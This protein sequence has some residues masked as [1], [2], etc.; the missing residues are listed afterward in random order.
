MMTTNTIAKNRGRRSIVIGELLITVALVSTACGG[1]STSSGN[2]AATATAV[3]APTATTP[4]PVVYVQGT[5]QLAGTT[6]VP[7]VTSIEL[8]GEGDFQN[9]VT[10][11]TG[12]D[13]KYAFSDIERDGP[14][15]VW[16]L[17]NAAAKMIPHCTDVI[18]PAEWIG[19]IK[20]D[21]DHAV[22]TDTTSFSK[23]IRVSNAFGSSGWVSTTT[24]SSTASG[25]YAV[26]PD[27]EL[28]QGKT[29]ELDV[30]L[31]CK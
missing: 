23:L 4:Q 14:Y 21:P 17:I 16:V 8:H 27:V 3:P 30:A 20:N 5:V 29:I 10:V 12:T 1:S 2:T 7:F 19:G 22:T 28:T 9:S 15:E 26:S 25:L 31:T 6:Q 11:R 18:F 13:G 24:G